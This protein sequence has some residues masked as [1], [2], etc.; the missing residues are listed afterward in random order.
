[1]APTTTT[2]PPRGP[3]PTTVPASP[4]PPCFTVSPIR[5]GG[6]A[7][8]R[9]YSV[10]LAS[11]DGGPCTIDALTTV[12]VATASGTLVAAPGN[13]GEAHVN[14]HVDGPPTQTITWG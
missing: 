8:S 13:P 7:G 2:P 10:D 12:R 9:G 1:T 11:V 3:T 14:V 6:A 5:V 4:P